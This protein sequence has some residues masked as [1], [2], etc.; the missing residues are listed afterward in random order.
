MKIGID[1]NNVLRDT[2]KKIEQVYEKW[3]IDNTVE[4]DEFSYEIKSTVTT[5]DIMNHL[6]FRDKEHLYDFL[7]NDFTM[8]IFGHAGSVE[9]STM[10]DLNDFYLSMRDKH[11]IL[12]VSDEIGKSKPATLFF[13]SKFGCL[14]ETIKFYSE[15]TKKSMWDSVDILLTANPDLLLRKPSEKEVIK[16]ETLFNNEVETKY[17]I[18]KIKELESK[19]IEIYG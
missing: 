19:I 6:E 15:Q 4:N 14:V 17:T 7:Y 5:L 8:E 11:E 2:L 18:K 16:Y 12:I 3:Y 13:I 10:N 9:M 1:L